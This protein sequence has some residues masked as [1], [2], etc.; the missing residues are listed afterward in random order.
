MNI[1]LKNGVNM[2]SSE[3]HKFA[4]DFSSPCIAKVM[5]AGN[6]RSTIVG[7]SICRILEE[8]GHEVFRINHLG[9]WGAYFGILIERLKEVYPNF[10]IEKPNLSDLEIL[11][12]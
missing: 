1:I 9:D 6:L 3:K 11:Y 10:L 8:C 12:K 2:N 5:N 4:V 7:D